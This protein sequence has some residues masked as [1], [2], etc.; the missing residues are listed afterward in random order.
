MDKAGK[1][2][3]SNLDPQQNRSRAFRDE[4]LLGPDLNMQENIHRYAPVFDRH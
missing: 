2:A 4:W 3:G 1:T